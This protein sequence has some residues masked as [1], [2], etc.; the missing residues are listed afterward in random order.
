MSIPDKTAQR[1]V[2]ILREVAA[3]RVRKPDRI[4]DSVDGDSTAICWFAG[5][6]QADIEVFHDGE[7]LAAIPVGGGIPATIVGVE[8]TPVG[9]RIALDLI[10]DAM[11]PA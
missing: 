3:H 9:I 6:A 8:E 7:C 1:L 11:K 2:A 10:A 5:N 4:V